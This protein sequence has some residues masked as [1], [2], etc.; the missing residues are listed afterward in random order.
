MVQ[1][2]NCKLNVLFNTAETFPKHTSTVFSIDLL[3]FLAALQGLVYF[4]NKNQLA[5]T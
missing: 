1:P 4:S 2:I 3:T 5:E